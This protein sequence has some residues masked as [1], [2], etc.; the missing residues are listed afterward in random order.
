MGEH[1]TAPQFTGLS[2]DATG[3]TAERRTDPLP[4]RAE[5]NFSYQARLEGWTIWA[6]RY[7]RVYCPIHEP[8]PG[9]KM[10]RVS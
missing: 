5:D 1:Y 4:S 2:C 10:V 7:R 8:Q 6:A 3:C 9:H